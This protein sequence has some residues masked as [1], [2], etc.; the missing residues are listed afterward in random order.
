MEADIAVV[1]NVND[2]LVVS[3]TTTE[4]HCWEI[5]QYSRRDTLEVVG[6]SNSVDSSAFEEMMRGALKKIGVETDEQDVETC[7]CLQEK[8]KNYSEIF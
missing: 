6:I 8:R 4:K 2:T 3:L 5:A 1:R 7:H